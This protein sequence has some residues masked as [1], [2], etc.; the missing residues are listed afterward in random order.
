M[1]Q[2][3][4]L[5][6]ASFYIILDSGFQ[7]LC[8]N[9]VWH[10]EAS[11]VQIGRSHLGMPSCMSKYRFVR[12]RIS[13]LVLKIISGTWRPLEADPGGRWRLI[14]EASQVQ[15]LRS[16]TICIQVCLNIGLLESGFQ[17]LC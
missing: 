7:F 8:Q 13:I 15:I 11:Q 10:L 2:I 4:D 1:Q 3:W 9:N 6:E 12:V 16:H 5:L 14:L 17:F